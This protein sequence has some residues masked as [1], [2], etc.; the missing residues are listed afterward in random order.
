MNIEFAKRLR[1]AR[2]FARSLLDEGYLYV[3]EWIDEKHYSAFIKMHHQYNG[4]TIKIT[5]RR[6]QWQAYK[7]NKLIKLE[8]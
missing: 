8:Q 2:S 3:F 4:N 7:N 1:D 5:A 6:D